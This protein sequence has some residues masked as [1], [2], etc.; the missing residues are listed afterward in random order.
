[1][2]ELS[3]LLLFG[4]SRFIWSTASS[5]V[6]IIVYIHFVTASLFALCQDVSSHGKP[7]KVME[8]HYFF[9]A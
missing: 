9:Q 5:C 2:L 3:S 1:M 7:G 4:L 6:L 8:F